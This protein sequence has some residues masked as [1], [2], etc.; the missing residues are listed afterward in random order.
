MF[1]KLF[2]TEVPES[3]EGFEC[4]DRDQMKES[5][6]EGL[7]DAQEVS[8]VLQH[9]SGGTADAGF[10]YY[11]DSCIPRREKASSSWSRPCPKVQRKTPSTHGST[12]T[13]RVATS[14]MATTRRD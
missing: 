5:W 11:G 1:G 8:P 12:R 7:D 10:S 6:P 2:D 4:K 3:I 9:Y 14:S 13:R